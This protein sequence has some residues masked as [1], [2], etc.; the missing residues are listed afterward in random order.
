MNR[1]FERI[2]RA[3]LRRL[4][5]F[6]RRHREH[7][8]S[9]SRPTG[10]FEQRFLC[11]ALCQGAGLHF[12]DGSN[13]VKDFDVYEFYADVPGV[14]I[15]YRAHWCYDFGPSKFG[16]QEKTTLHPE[17]EGRRVDVFVRALPVGPG[18]DPIEAVRD[19]LHRAGT[20]TARL[21]AQKG[22][23]I[24]E[25]DELLGAVAWPHPAD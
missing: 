1:S 12:V 19:Y 9:G 16:R 2:A 22:V 23:V 17:Y 10:V 4:A 6:S 7:W 18:A 20:K 24:L 13:G 15:P 14:T 21:L 5:A 8:F 3:D 11:S 25:P